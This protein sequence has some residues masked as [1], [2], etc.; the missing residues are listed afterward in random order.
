MTNRRPDET[1]PRRPRPRR[2]H[3]DVVTEEAD[4]IRETWEKLLRVRPL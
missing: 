3:V 4:L 2:P 1:A